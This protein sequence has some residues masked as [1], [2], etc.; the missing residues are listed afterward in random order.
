MQKRK[1]IL[2]DHGKMYALTQSADDI[3]YIEVM[4]GGFAMENY[5]IPLTQE[6]Q[7]QYDEEGKD[8][9]DRLALDI[10]KAPVSFASRRV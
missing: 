6:E 8:F 2:V 9:L 7:Q 3:L 10:A 4:V 5:I 1:D